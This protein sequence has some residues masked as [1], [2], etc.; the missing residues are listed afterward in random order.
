VHHQSAREP[1][2]RQATMAEIDR[3]PVVELHR[4]SWF[5]SATISTTQLSIAFR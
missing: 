2:S 1:V 4:P 5:N 3:A